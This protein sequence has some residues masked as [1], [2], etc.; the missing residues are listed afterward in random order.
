MQE[1][2]TRVQTLEESPAWDH[3]LNTS[4]GLAC[5]SPTHSCNVCPLLLE[6][7]NIFIYLCLWA[8]DFVYE[9]L[10]VYMPI[11]MFWSINTFIL[12]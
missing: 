11:L 3:F 10:H 6:P 9:Y 12:V 1:I 7:T 4:L 2:I 8:I 5:Y